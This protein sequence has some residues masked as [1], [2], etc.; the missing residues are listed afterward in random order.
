MLKTACLMTSMAL[1]FGF[2]FVAKAADDHHA[3]LVSVAIPADI[4]SSNPG[5]NRDFYS[6]VVLTHVVEGLVAYREDLSVGPML[7]TNYDVS[8][9]GLT[10]TFHLRDGVTFQNGAPLTSAD[11]VW[12]WKRYIDPATQWQ[13]VNFFDGSDGPKVESIE[14]PDK[15]TV[16]FKLDR[17]SALFLAYMASI[18]CDAGILHPESVDATGQWL[19]PVGTGPYKFG[20]W[21]RDRYVEL[22]RFAGYASLPGEP[23]GLAGGKHPYAD[24]IRFVVTPERSVMKTALFAGDLVVDSGDARSLRKR[25]RGG[26]SSITLRPSRR[27]VLPLR[28][29]RSCSGQ[30][31]DPSLRC[32]ALPSHS[33]K[34]LIGPSLD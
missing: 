1:P 2:S 30:V 25:S 21:Q 10:Y 26:F 15:Q 13:C 7:A 34:R 5:V 24:H 4:R 18:Q 12:S 32:V 19:K 29:V 6:D 22:E 17:K 11:V 16:V 20:D 14:A 28:L 8:Q 33:S 31:V 23:D 27:T 9:D 3:D